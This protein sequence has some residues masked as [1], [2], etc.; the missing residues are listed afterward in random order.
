L[1]KEGQEELANELLGCAEH[2]FGALLN[3]QAHL[4]CSHT[5]LE[6]SS[7]NLIQ[8]LMQRGLNTRARQQ[9]EDMLVRLARITAVSKSGK[10]APVGSGEA[11]D[12][13]NA[14]TDNTWG[15]KQATAKASMK[16]HSVAD[17]K[18]ALVALT[19]PQDACRDASK[20]ESTLVVGCLVNLGTCAL[21]SP[22]AGGPGHPVL[23]ICGGGCLRWLLHLTVLDVAASQRL[24]GALYRLTSKAAA[25]ADDS[26]KAEDVDAALQMRQ[27]SLV[28]LAAS[29]KV[30]VAEVVAQ[31]VKTAKFY[32]AKPVVRGSPRM[33]LFHTQLLD[34]LSPVLLQLVSTGKVACV[35]VDGCGGGY[36]CP[37]ALTDPSLNSARRHTVVM[38]AK[39]SPLDMRMHMSTHLLV[40][41]RSSRLRT[42][43]VFMCRGEKVWERGNRGADRLTD[44]HM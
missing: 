8:Q 28:Y 27:L 23:S 22:P 14:C 15:S 44:K 30:G 2:S 16:G 13:E 5:D 40:V 33:A 38:L 9:S 3:M 42:Y 26:D 37:C 43:V 35:V 6:K 18:E 21:A 29:G 20:D 25:R 31:V 12:K 41:F 24:A 34:R 1:L 32:D 19:E 36:V 11:S 7:L 17:W 39:C 10:K 4:T